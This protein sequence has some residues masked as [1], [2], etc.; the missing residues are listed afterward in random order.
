MA[1]LITPT[2]PNHKLI[3]NRRVEE[4][5][6][7]T[8]QRTDLLE[9]RF[10]GVTKK[11]HKRKP[12]IPSFI[13]DPPF[14]LHLAT[15]F[16]GRKIQK[17]IGR[18]FKHEIN[19]LELVQTL[20][21][22]ENIAFRK[23]Y[24]LEGCM[25][26]NELLLPYVQSIYLYTLALQW[27]FTPSPGSLTSAWSDLGS[28]RDRC[29]GACERIKISREILGRSHF[30]LNKKRF[31]HF[32]FWWTN[33]QQCDFVIFIWSTNKALKEHKRLEVGS[34]APTMDCLCRLVRGQWSGMAWNLLHAEADCDANIIKIQLGCQK[35]FGCQT[36]KVKFEMHDSKAFV[37]QGYWCKKK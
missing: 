36:C 7:L 28:D 18:W 20:V 17:T 31:H 14:V 11:P 37:C 30:K 4:I 24:L 12:K 10:R 6:T 35:V 3:L 8:K 19:Q 26:K 9:H 1:N 2:V 22:E 25:A 29:A 33:T 5:M 27:P 32:L 21:H 13:M 23:G 16:W 34:N 15:N